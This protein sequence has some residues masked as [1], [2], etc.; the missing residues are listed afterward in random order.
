MKKSAARK[1]LR[2]PEG[3]EG[4]FTGLHLEKENREINQWAIDMLYIKPQDKILEIGYGPGAAIEEMANRAPEGH[5]AGID[6]SELMLTQAKKRNAKAIAQ[7]RVDLR[8]ADANNLPEFNTTFDKIIAINNVMYWENQV[9]ALHNLRQVLEPGGFIA[10]IIQRGE[11][12]FKTG[13][14][15]DEIG[16]Y[17]QCLNAAGYVNVQ[18]AAQPVEKAEKRY[19]KAERKMGLAYGKR[20]EAHRIAGICIYGF[21]PKPYDSIAEYWQA[22]NAYNTQQRRASVARCGS[23]TMMQHSNANFLFE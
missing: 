5:I 15:N 3:T 23:M 8:H 20:S 13:Q 22:L 4:Y 6:Y 1:N 18:V 14:C 12:Q 2:K 7:G 21:N 10:L 17:I 19:T 16:Y 9:I 11:D